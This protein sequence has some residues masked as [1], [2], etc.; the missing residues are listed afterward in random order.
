MISRFLPFPR[1]AHSMPIYT[2]FLAACVYGMPT[3]CLHNAHDMPTTCLYDMPIRHAYA[4]PIY[5]MP[6]TCLYDITLYAMY[7]VLGCSGREVRI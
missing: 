2:A 3:T 4:M 7:L 6:T 1:P 5:D